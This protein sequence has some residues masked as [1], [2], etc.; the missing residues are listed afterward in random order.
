MENRN[1]KKP[2]VPA[3]APPSEPAK[4][5]GCTLPKGAKKMSGAQRFMN[6]V[7]TAAIVE[8]VLQP[9]HLAAKGIEFLTGGKVGKDVR[10]STGDA[11]NE[12]SE[13]STGSP[14]ARIGH[15]VGTVGS[16]A[17]IGGVGA[18]KAA[19]T[20]GRAK[21]TKTIKATMD[22]MFGNAPV[23]PAVREAAYRTMHKI[24]APLVQKAVVKAATKVAT[25]AAI[26]AVAGEAVYQVAAG[27]PNK[28]HKAK[29]PVTKAAPH[30]LPRPRPPGV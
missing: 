27:K 11:L 22:K 8:P 12:V 7:V 29:P 13:C 1:N 5:K 6:G 25:H 16:A 23:P 10:R 17:L 18:A 9:I 2:A 15:L 19:K 28:G 20:A 4:V 26:G 30:A 14:E 3:S 24:A 21:A